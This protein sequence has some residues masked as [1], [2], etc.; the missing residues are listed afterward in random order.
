MDLSQSPSPAKKAKSKSFF[1]LESGLKPITN[2]RCQVGPDMPMISRAVHSLCLVWLDFMSRLI[3]DISISFF[4]LSTNY[5]R[6]N[7][8]QFNF[9]KMFE[10]ICKSFRRKKWKRRIWIEITKPNL[11][12]NFNELICQIIHLG[13]IL[14]KICEAR[15]HAKMPQMEKYL[16][17][18]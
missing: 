1:D 7:G 15:Q 12:E 16:A 8:R 13:P 10:I 4:L 2:T 11:R 17:I 6:S 5:F 3:W 18:C 9:D 14:Y